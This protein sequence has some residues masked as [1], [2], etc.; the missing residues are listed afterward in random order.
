M[1]TLFK[2]SFP[3][4]AVLVILAFIGVQPLSAYKDT[5]IQAVE[6][7]IN[8]AKTVVSSVAPLSSQFDAEIVEAQFQKAQP[9][10]SQMFD[11]SIHLVA[12][13]TGLPIKIRVKPRSSF[14]GEPFETRQIESDTITHSQ[15]VWVLLYSKKDGYLFGRIGPL[16]WTESELTPV[17][18]SSV[19]NYD[20]LEAAK[21]KATK[22]VS[23]SVD[24]KDKDIVAMRLE[25][26]QYLTQY[27]EDAWKD[28]FSTTGGIYGDMPSRSEQEKEVN[29]GFLN[30]IN[31]YLRVEIADKDKVES[32]VEQ[33]W[34][35]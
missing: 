13:K 7:V 18:E 6:S 24:G 22:S 21:D 4:V 16:T 8:Q 25:I 35:R 3:V 30:I 11:S 26:E 9:S 17:D 34:E 10:L 31:S 29:K 33:E 23:F 20:Y 5:T 12:P 2:F 19:R 28:F 15:P 1:V 27:Q 14:T 32:L